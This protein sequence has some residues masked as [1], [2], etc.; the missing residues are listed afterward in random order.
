MFTFHSH[1]PLVEHAS[2]VIHRSPEEV[3]RFIGERFF[4]NYPR[5][6]PEVCELEQ[7][8]S[9]PIRAGMRARQVRVDLGHRSE[10]SFAVT[11][12]EPVQRVCFEGVSSAYRCDYEMK[13]IFPQASTLISFTFELSQFEIYLRPFESPIREA[14]RHGVERTVRNLKAL[15]EAETIACVPGPILARRPAVG[16][17]TFGTHQGASLP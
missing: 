4:A 12:F 10:S 1:S 11:I 3:F 16:P 17:R 9:G 8:G 2:V 15:I 13:R 5:W 6:S 7:I 14:I